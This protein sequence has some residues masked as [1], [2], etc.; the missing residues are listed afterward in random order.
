MTLRD[1]PAAD[2]P[3]SRRRFMHAAAA[4]AAAV[5]FP[6]VFVPKVHGEPVS[7]TVRRRL[8]GKTGLSVSEIGL[9]GHSW[10]TVERDLGIAGEPVTEKLAV[11]MVA[12]AIDGGVNFFDTT[13]Q[14]ERVMLGK[15]LRTLNKRDGLHVT[16]RQNIKSVPGDRKKLRDLV[17]GALRDELPVGVIDI[18][19]IRAGKSRLG[20]GPV[21]DI[22]Y[23]LE[24]MEKMRDEGKVRFFGLGCHYSPRE[25]KE[26]IGA[27]GDHFDVI[28][29]I[30]NLQHD[31]QEE[32]MKMAR[33][34][35]LGVAA[36]KAFGR[37]SLLKAAQSSSNALVSRDMNRTAQALLKYVLGNDD[38]AVT[39]LGMHSLA[40]L[41]GN[42]AVSGAAV[43][44]ED[45]EIW[46]FFKPR[47]IGFYC[48]FH[49]AHV[50]AC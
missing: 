40:A 43:T 33:E 10:A 8:L 46:N 41:R 6:H 36:I 31:Q 24:E 49:D 37:G 32:I 14:P 30:Y 3:I 4:G 34:R 28:S 44:E 35:G 47:K 15:A 20:K 11:E 38:L 16:L 29:P 42:L 48:P 22:S 45:R 2:F 26:W 27:Y 19:L 39:N 23:A 13:V 12:E 17:E 50:R 9:G 7:S 25:W 21:V 5:A 18:L 1:R